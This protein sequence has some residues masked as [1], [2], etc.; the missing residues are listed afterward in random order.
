MIILKSSNAAA[1]FVT[2]LGS[3]TLYGHPGDII[4]ELMTDRLKT[5]AT[6]DSTVSTA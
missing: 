1:G 3:D 6:T 4:H 5:E 2:V